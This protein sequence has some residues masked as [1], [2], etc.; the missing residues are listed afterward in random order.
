MI[1]PCNQWLIMQ[2]RENGLQFI[3]NNKCYNWQKN[4]NMCIIS[5]K[6]KENPPD[7]GDLEIAWIQPVRAKLV[8]PG[9][10][11]MNV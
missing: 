7:P 8:I 5:S 4:L 10:R 9:A 2:E 1:K 11:Y 3:S 6:L